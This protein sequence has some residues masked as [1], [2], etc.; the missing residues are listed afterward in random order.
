MSPI[1]LLLT[2]LQAEDFQKRVKV[3][4][5]RVFVDDR[6][7]F[8]GTW[9]T[10][11]VTA[12]DL[13]TGPGRA[14]WKSVVV[15]IDGQERVRIPLRSL[16][17]PV[18]WPPCDSAE[19]RP[20]LKRQMETADDVKTLVLFV[21]TEKGD[22]EIYRGEP[23]ETRL[24][25]TPEAFTVYLAD[26]PLYRVSPRGRR[27]VV[28]EDVLTAL[29]V[30][31]ERAKLPLVR[32]APGLSRGC[33]LH[34]LYLAK[35][36]WKG[37]SGHEEDPKGAGYTDEGARS[38]KRSV[39]SPFS[40]HETPLDALE[41]L[42]ATLYHRV[43][44]LTPGLTEVGI[45]WAWR[46]DGLGY[47]VIDVGN[48]DAR[49]DPKVFPVLCPASGQADVPLEFGLGAR[50]TPNPLPEG[51]DGAGYPVTIQFPERGKAPELKLALSESGRE[52][53]CFVSTPGAPARKDWPQPGVFSLIPKAKLKPG[54][55]YV[56]RFET[57]DGGAREWTFTTRK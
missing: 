17:K 34:S 26:R 22:A 23:A 35:N 1:L 37:L 50:E 9:K 31:R 24:D 3:D 8:E 4:G 54:T 56:V 41:S 55:S 48:A 53:P 25:R 10:A 13:P 29:N 2:L 45:G 11:D 14:P 12:R 43:S 7:V 33:D 16:A 27:P 57:Q 15:L 36:D 40:G 20:L 5:A 47:L 21:S 49:V 42:M 19:L 6:V 52:V 51:V 38:G 28:P 30:H 32:H 46:R 18:A 39:I 44:V